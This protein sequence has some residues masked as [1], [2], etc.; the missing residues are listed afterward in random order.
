MYQNLYPQILYPTYELDRECL[1]CHRP[2]P[3][4]EH[5][6]RVHCPKTTNPDGTIRD[7]KSDRH[8]KDKFP[9]R[10]KHRHIIKE[11]K[12][13]S[14]RIEAMVARKGYT[15]T[16]NDL[17]AYDIN[18]TDSNLFGINESGISIGY[19]LDYKITSNPIYKT[20]LIERL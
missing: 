19:F 5:A 7:C 20:H 1:F 2:I 15:V 11:K 3:D 13:V 4:Q 12:S 14:E 17:D 6:L 10:E 18:L 8:S 16:T 9:E